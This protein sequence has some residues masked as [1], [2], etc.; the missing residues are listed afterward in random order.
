MV[1]SIGVLGYF[2]KR[3]GYPRPPLILGMILGSLVEK[4]LYISTAAYGFAWLSRTK[5][6]RLVLCASA[7]SRP[8][9]IMISALL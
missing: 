5:E 9:A 8:S 3:L 7:S 2:M 6:N 1:V 4:Y